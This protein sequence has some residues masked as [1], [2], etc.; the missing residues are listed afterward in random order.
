MTAQQFR[1]WRL[2]QTLTQKTTGDALGVAPNTVARWERDERAIPHWVPLLIQARGQG[3]VKRYTSGIAADYRRLRAGIAARRKAAHA[4]RHRRQWN[5]DKV[6]K[7]E[8]EDLVE[9]IETELDK[10]AAAYGLEPKQ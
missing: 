7:R 9:W 10:I 4:E 8:L 1:K 2:S 6:V 3:E 5:L